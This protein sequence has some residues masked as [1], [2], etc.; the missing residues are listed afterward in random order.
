MIE[1][2]IAVAP[3]QGLTDARRGLVERRFRQALKAPASAVSI[4]KRPAAESAPLSFAQQRLWFIDQLEP[5]SPAYHVATA[6]RLRGPVDPSAIE[7]AIGQIIQRHEILRTRFPA[8]DGTPIQVIESRIPFD[9]PISDLSDL[10]AE[11]RQAKAQAAMKAEAQRPFDLATGPLLRASLFRLSDVEHLLLIVMHHIISDG[12]SSGVFFRELQIAYD[13][14]SEETATRFS[15]LLT[16]YADYSVWQQQQAARDGFFDDHLRWWK[17][18][19]D[20]APSSLPLPTDHERQ[21]Q[22]PIFRGADKATTIAEPLS[23]QL[24]SVSRQYSAT[25]FMTLLTALV[26]TLHRWTQQTDLV[27]GTVVAGRTLRELENLI[28]CF[29]NFI[30]VRVRL[31]GAESAAEILEQV[32]SAVLESSAHQDCP[33]DKIVEAV[34]PNRQVHQ[35]PLYNVGLLF[36]NYP[37]DIFQTGEL[38]GTMQTVRTDTALL[39]LRFIADMEGENLALHCEYDTGL[40]DATTIDALLESFTSVLEKL[41]SQPDQALLGFQLSPALQRQLDA[42]QAR[43]QTQTL[44]IA[45]TF[46]CEPLADFL[47]FWME[48]LEL[49]VATRFAPYNQIFQELL[50][51]TSLLSTNQSG[52]NVLLIRPEDWLRNLPR[53]PDAE[54]G[55]IEEH[56]N[57][58]A[59]QLADAL[60]TAAARSG[61]PFLVCICPPGA[62]TRAGNFGQMLKH[63]EERFIQKVTS[64]AGVHV[65]TPSEVLRLYP[66]KEYDDPQ[67][68]EIGHVPYTPVFFAALGTIIARKFHALKRPPRKVIALDCDNTLWSGICGEDGP[69]GVKIDEPRRTLQQFMRAQMD[70]GLLLCLCSKNNPEDVEEVFRRHDMPLKRE[71]FAACRLNWVPKSE[72]LKSLAAEL[73]LGLDSFIFVDDNPIECAEIEANCPG[74]IALQLPEN[75][76]AIPQ[77]LSHVWVFDHLKITDEDRKRTAAYLEN[78]QREQFQAQSISFADFLSGLN[79]QIRIEEV[80]EAQVSR[81]AQLTQRTNQFNMTTHRHTEAE[82]NKLRQ[83]SGSKVLAIT[84]SDRFGEYGLVGVVVYQLT[85]HALDVDTFLL[86]CR[87]LGK[88]VEHRI[89]AHLGEIAQGQGR[90][91]VDLHFVHSP[92]NKPAFQFLESVGSSFRQSSNGSILFRFPADFAASVSFNPQSI[93]APISASAE[94][95]TETPSSTAPTF[96]ARFACC[97]WIAS[98]AS[99]PETILNLIESLATTR[100]SSQE[101]YESPRNDMERTLCELWQKLLHVERVG[102]RDDFFALGGTSLLAVRLFAQIE[103]L[104]GKKLPLVT[105][106]RAPTIEQLAGLLS[107][108][109]TGQSS[110]ALVAI[111]PKGSRP[112]LVLIHGAGGG[113]LWGY[114]NLAAALPSEQP[115]YAI[116]PRWTAGLH[117][118]RVE[119]MAERY[120]AELRALA[121]KGPYHLGGY[122][123]GG[124]VAYEMAR[125]LQAKGEPT[126]LVL[127]IDCA[128]PNG[129]YER[130]QWWKPS[131]LADFLKNSIYWAQDFWRLPPPERHELLKRKWAVLRRSLLRRSDQSGRPAID[132]DDFIDTSQFPEDELKLWQ[133]HLRAGSDYVPQ[134]YRGHVTLLR[135]RRHPFLCSFDPFY[136]W[137]DLAQ[138]GVESRLIPGSHENIFVEPDVTALARQVDDCLKA[139]FA[140]NSADS[141]PSLHN[142][143]RAGVKDE[144]VREVAERVS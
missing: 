17:R 11:E 127:L 87:V 10:P 28:G 47:K 24:N 144:V 132:V 27:I 133:V 101:T 91:W 67:A 86:S 93:A 126:G 46:T 57:Q 78:R 73:N 109:K 2:N 75:L 63:V 115:V 4:P 121:P 23:R 107:R 55:E 96:A 83:E 88:G 84:V 65:L 74:V 111:Q 129:S 69:S 81:V 135:T 140:T 122:C 72:N 35:N 25:P 128:A 138:D 51:P 113:I 120:I 40:F 64:I 59:A 134:P 116:D 43:T 82:I 44:A 34:N 30:P 124:Y 131:F 60:K 66:V 89:L 137:G 130:V 20:K 19:L 26:I 125:Q 48:K 41:L 18:K 50:D 139:A 42:I 31:A 117:E 108:K 105:L 14:A 15:P 123:F 61:T 112:P 90:R 38:H 119:D 62:A 142:E 12:W 92:K 32:K 52:A 100:Q 16:Q 103:K 141:F 71:D 70:A 136:G 106:F 39:D 114:A 29:M 45:G 36:Q 77:F 99:N 6:L 68:D 53:S 94:K 3:R 21:E 85:G 22:P 98:E 76:E 9:L 95:A 1:S 37:R 104:T 97:R 8:V 80:S 102:I 54:L 143:E 13:A 33:F 118:T 56:L 5:G 58:T 49:P 110:S 79:L 7:N